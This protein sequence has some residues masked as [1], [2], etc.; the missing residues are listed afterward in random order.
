MTRI[1]GMTLLALGAAGFAFAGNTLTPEID[2]TS[3][4]GAITLLS[5]GLLVLRARRR[6]K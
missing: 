1:I 6:S 5:G 4:A 2:A 3:A